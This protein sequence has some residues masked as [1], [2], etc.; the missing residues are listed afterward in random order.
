M[1]N[2]VDMMQKGLISL[3]KTINDCRRFNDHEIDLVY[4][5]AWSRK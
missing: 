3:C 2:I 5:L 1:D 4:T